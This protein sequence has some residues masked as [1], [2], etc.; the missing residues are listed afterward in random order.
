MRNNFKLWSPKQTLKVISRWQT[1]W[2]GATLYVSGF[3]S[4]HMTL[5]VQAMASKSRSQLPPK[6]LKKKKKKE[7]KKKKRKKTRDNRSC[8][9]FSNENS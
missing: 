2:K 6:K 1:L 5:S 9:D 4:V 8:Q 3:S 7:K